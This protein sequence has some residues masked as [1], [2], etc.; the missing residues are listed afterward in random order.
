MPV[1]YN[2]ALWYQ[3]K[4]KLQNAINNSKHMLSAYYVLGNISDAEKSYI[5]IHKGYKIASRSKQ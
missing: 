1:N 4:S 3:G 2:T 5:I